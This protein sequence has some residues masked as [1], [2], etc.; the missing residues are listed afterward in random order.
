[1]KLAIGAVLVLVV[2]PSLGWLL[3]AGFCSLP[4]VRFSIACGHNAYLLLPVAVLLG[5]LVVW[6]AISRFLLPGSRN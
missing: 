4:S 1:M 6:F 2:G 3:L 5:T